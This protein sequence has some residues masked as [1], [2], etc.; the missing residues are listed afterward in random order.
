MT[1]TTLQA[2]QIDVAGVPTAVIDTA[3][4]AGV[5][6]GQQ[7]PPVLLLHGSGPGVTAPANWRPVIPS[8]WPPRARP[9]CGASC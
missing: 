3:A 6:D 9:R 2:G 8:R 1:T 7:A 5:P 4:P